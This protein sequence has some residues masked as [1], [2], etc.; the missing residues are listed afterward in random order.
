M[1]KTAFKPHHEL[2]GVDEGSKTSRETLEE[3]SAGLAAAAAAAGRGGN[4][5]LAKRLRELRE[6]LKEA[7]RREDS[8]SRGASPHLNSPR[9]TDEEGF[10]TV[11]PKKSKKKLS[12]Q[13]FSK[14]TR[15]YVSTGSPIS[16]RA[17]RPTTNTAAASST[18]PTATQTQTRAPTPAAAATPSAYRGGEQSAAAT[19]GEKKVKV[20]PKCRNCLEPY[21]GTPY[22]HPEEECPLAGKLKSLPKTQQKQNLEGKRCT[23]CEGPHN[24]FFCW[25]FNRLRANLGNLPIMIRDTPDGPE[26][27]DD[28]DNATLWA[29]QRELPNPQPFGPLPKKGAKRP[30]GTPSPTSQVGGP[31]K[32]A[33]VSKKVVQGISYAGASGGGISGPSSS[34]NPTSAVPSMDSASAGAAGASAK[35]DGLFSIAVVKKEHVKDKFYPPISFKQYRELQEDLDFRIQTLIS[36]GL[37]LRLVKEINR[38]NQ[39]GWAVPTQVEVDMVKGLVKESSKDTWVA[40]TKEELS[41]AREAAKRAAKEAENAVFYRTTV[42]TGSA[43]EM[44]DD[45]L[46]TAVTFSKAQTKITGKLAFHSAYTVKSRAGGTHKVLKV[47]LDRQGV[48]EFHDKAGNYIHL[49]TRGSFYLS[50]PDDKTTWLKT[51]DDDEAE[52]EASEAEAEAMDTTVSAPKPTDDDKDSDKDSEAPMLTEEAPDPKG[53]EKEKKGKPEKA[54]SQSDEIDVVKHS[55]SLEKG[56][57]EDDRETEAETDSDGSQIVEY[58]EGKAEKPL[59]KVGEENPEAQKGADE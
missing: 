31:P 32:R 30:R 8:P 46:R 12:V 7:T 28:Y 29:R 51:Q 39:R 53:G 2:Y 58:L 16:S 4:A 56:E 5:E 25:D 45:F 36:E 59:R 21:R 40:M 6:E 44:S 15:P 52:A 48:I 37:Q 18:G 24:R 23:Y 57:E 19:P 33:F 26:A 17:S 35:E 1:K 41:A 11:T 38:D 27:T 22:G 13:L 50:D 47:E 14:K 9:N 10:T 20:P 42:L 3:A 55:I 54:L 43:A 34:G 49:F